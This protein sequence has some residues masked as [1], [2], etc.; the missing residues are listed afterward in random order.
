MTL[1][2]WD[3]PI[4]LQDSY[5]DWLSEDIVADFTHYARVIFER[6]HDRVSKFFTFNEPIVFC[7]TYPLPEGCFA[8][9]AIPKK[10]QPHVCGHSVLLAHA[11]AYHLGKMITPLFPSA[12]RTTEV[13]KFLDE[14]E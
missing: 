13:T 5:G 1:Y 14:F 8:S 3:L 10:Q 9:S 12:S 4:A 7:S 6:Y 11:Q 2:H